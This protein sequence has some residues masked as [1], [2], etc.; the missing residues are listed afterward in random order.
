MNPE[1]MRVRRATLEDIGS[2]TVLWR[3][4]NFDADVLAKRITEFQVVEG[5]GGDILGAVGLQ[6][7][8]QQALIHSEGFFDF[9]HAEYSR[10]LLWDRI[11][12]LATNHGLLRIWTQEQ[13]PFWNHCGMN[14]ADRESL[15][16]LPAVWRSSGDWL[17]LKLKDNLETII[18]A[19]KEFEL[20]MQAEKARTQRS[21]QHAKVLKTI[22][23]FIVLV[24]VSVVLA[25][26]F[27]MVRRYSSL[28][29]FG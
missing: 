15:A 11:N 8:E 10:P 28:G 6:I 4:M 5:G 2:L 24:V 23:M 3:S 9:A 12:S 25:A 20:F 22:A 19:D 16:K 21:L 1:T 26:A 18:Y 13:A 7:A 29:R 14:R 17:T 27:Y